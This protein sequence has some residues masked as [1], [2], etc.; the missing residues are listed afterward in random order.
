ML[1]NLLDK[2]K[3]S[4]VTCNS[5][6]FDYSTLLDFAFMQFKNYI[7]FNLFFVSANR[8]TSQTASCFSSD[9]SIIFYQKQTKLHINADKIHIV[10]E[11]KIPIR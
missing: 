7:Y 6:D 11:K 5:Q 8:L 1:P 2:K 10:K 4:T 3:Y 9:I